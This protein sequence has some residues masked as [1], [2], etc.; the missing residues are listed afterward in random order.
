MQ[1]LNI[2]NP[3][4]PKSEPIADPTERKPTKTEAKLGRIEEKINTLQN[5]KTELETQQREETEAERRRTIESAAAAKIPAIEAARKAY[6]EAQAKFEA[7]LDNMLSASDAAESAKAN[8]TAAI[9]R[10]H[11]ELG[12]VGANDSEKLSLIP[13]VEIPKPGV[14]IARMR[15]NAPDLQ[16]VL[17][18]CRNQVKPHRGIGRVLL[19]IRKGR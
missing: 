10:A 4:T 3:V 6:E 18:N 14:V 17:Y 8:Y 13:K 19:D 9:S 12:S 7:A 2:G 1:T 15:D 5:E 16:S 11:W